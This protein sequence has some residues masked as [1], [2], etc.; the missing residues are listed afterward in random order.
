MARGIQSKFQKCRK[1]KDG[2]ELV[3]H[4]NNIICPNCIHDKA[5]YYDN[6]RSPYDTTYKCLRCGY[7]WKL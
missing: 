3:N 2:F 4:V 6:P 7:R 1:D 5:L